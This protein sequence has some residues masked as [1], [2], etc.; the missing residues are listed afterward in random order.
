[1]DSDVVF[2]G[3]GLASSLAA[4]LLKQ[5]SPELRVTMLE[6]GSTLGGNHTWSFHSGDLTSEQH[7][8]MKPVVRHAWPRYEV[9][10]P[11]FTR[12]L[13]TGYHSVE[14]SDLHATVSALL[15]DDIV[16]DTEASDVT[17]TSVGTPM[18]ARYR[19][20]AVF[21]GRGYVPSPSLRLGYQKFLGQV[22]EF[23]HPLSLA[24]PILMDATVAQTDGFRFVYVLPFSERT[25]LVE[26]TY[27]SDTP[28]VDAA[29]VREAIAGY[30]ERAGWSVERVVREEQ[31]VLPVA[32]SGDI[33]QFWDEG[34]EVARIG[35]RAA[36]FHPTTGYSLP[37]AVQTAD[38]LAD[39]GIE[40]TR[41]WYAFLRTLS[42][43]AWKR[44]A[45]YRALNRMLFLAGDPH[46]RYRVLERFYKLPEGLIARFYAQRLTV[47]DRVRIVVGAP[48]VPVG[49]ALRA[50]IN[51]VPV[52]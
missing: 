14:S 27:Y 47:L 28:T 38:R 37:N 50:L 10:F 17:P 11:K 6:R 51:T 5:R 12:V 31:G 40:A 8:W 19:A 36:L 7:A 21:D 49:G 44:G 46:E 42:V 48:P 30:V 13:E 15:G 29:V 3:G 16:L 18:G 52:R 4:Y 25:A 32:L 22:I 20:H 41:D 33:D 39:E 35:L 9:R 45:F 1:M 43:D 2:A 23:A 26:D 34:P 24:H